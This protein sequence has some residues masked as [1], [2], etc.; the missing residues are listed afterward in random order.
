MRKLMDD[1]NRTELNQSLQPFFDWLF[2]QPN[3]I[4]INTALS[5]TGAVEPVFRLPYVPLDLATRQIGFD[6]LSKIDSD[7][8]VGESLSLLQDGDFEV[9]V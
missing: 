5:M 6:L 8:I 4:S 1:K 3:P 7:E 9:L 2:C